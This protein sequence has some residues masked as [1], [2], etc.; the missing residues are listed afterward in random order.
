MYAGTYG[1]RL[2][3][4]EDGALWYE[5]EGRPRFRLEPLG[6]HRFGLDGMDSFRLE[7][8]VADGQSSELIGHYDDGRQDRNPRTGG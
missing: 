1:P 2:I 8:V 4:L 5:R 3:S 7:F 6:Q